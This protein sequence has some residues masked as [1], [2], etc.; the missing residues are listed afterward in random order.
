MSL[1]RGFKSEAE[2]IADE[3]REELGLL[4]GDVFDPH[5]LA[6]LLAIPIVPLSTLSQEA[7]EYFAVGDRAGRFSAVTIVDGT[8]RLIVHNDGHVL[9]RQRSNLSHELAHVL[10]EHE[11]VPPL[12]DD[13]F[14][15][16][17]SSVEDEA[18]FLGAALLVPKQACIRLAMN[19]VPLEAAARRYDVS[20]QL[21]RMRLNLSGATVIARRSRGTGQRSRTRGT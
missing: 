10:L 16:L 17:N 11:A 21:M 20:E 5:A 19:S 6:H 13:G 18:T 7:A 15:H 3:T 2:T 4:A 8:E 1:R 12:S 14:R 9:V